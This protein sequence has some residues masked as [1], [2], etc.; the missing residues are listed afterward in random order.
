MSTVINQRR[1]LPMLLTPRI[2]PPAHRRRRGPLMA[3][4]L[5]ISGDVLLL[6]S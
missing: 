1:L 6:Y 4:T 2:T 3:T 5:C